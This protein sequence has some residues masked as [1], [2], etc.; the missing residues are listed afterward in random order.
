MKWPTI[1]LT[2]SLLHAEE[3]PRVPKQ[4][5][6]DEAAYPAIE[7]LILVMETIRRRHPD[8]DQLTYDRLVNHALEGMLSSLD[9]HSS[10]IHPEMAA[11]MKSHGEVEPH[12]ASLGLTVGLRDGGPYISAMTAHGPAAKANAVLNAQILSIDGKNTKGLSLPQLIK[13]LNQPAGAITKL[14]IKAPSEPKSYEREITHVRVE[15]K[16]LT[17]AA[18]LAGHD[19][20][21]YLRL[22]QFSSDCHK[23]VE[24]AL[25]DLEDRGARALILD[26]RGN[27]GGDL[28][29][30]VQLLGLFLP[31][32]TTVVTVRTRDPQEAETHTTPEQKRRARNY[33]IVVLIDRMSAS[34]SELTA[35]CLQDLKRATI[36][37]EMS[38]GKGSVQNIIPM[39]NGTALRLTIA[40]YHT[41]SGRTPH[42]VGITP[43][44]SVNFTEVDRRNFSL[45]LAKETLPPV[46]QESLEKWQDPCI[47]EALKILNP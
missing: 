39:S 36:I 6:T 11:A 29:A 28:H 15:E 13:I 4:A 12:I 8:V 10:Y 32:K 5:D 17:H 20:I 3:I 1:F 42:G 26:L 45:S 34:A 21:A 41:P 33:P 35:G 44:R 43:D 23:E 30:T 19:H 18:L 31:P 24:K 38:Y 16:A 7:R 22:A 40:T 37:G 14:T 25:D 27:G 9:P 47:A 2:I 46:Q